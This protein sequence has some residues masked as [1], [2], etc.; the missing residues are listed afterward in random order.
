MTKQ[1][2]MTFIGMLLTLAAV[3]IVGLTIM[4]IVPVYIQQYT[5]S[6]SLK[7]I[8]IIPATECSSEPETNA[9]YIRSTILK[10]LDING[11]ADIQS[12]Q[13]KITPTESQVYKT[14]INYDVERP[15]FREI[16]LLFHFKNTIEVH[17]AES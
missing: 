14:T 6:K 8:Q 1:R 15:L 5:V 4:R 9:N 2:G 3:V 11:I 7:Q 17:C 13:I 12:E 16:N 10:Y